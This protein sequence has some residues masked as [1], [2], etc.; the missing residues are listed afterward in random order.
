MG[1]AVDVTFVSK[2]QAVIKNSGKINT[3]DTAHGSK[4]SHVKI[5]A[6]SQTKTAVQ[7]CKNI[8]QC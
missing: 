2:R 6:V 4:S 3:T 1:N 5:Q 8:I 7:V